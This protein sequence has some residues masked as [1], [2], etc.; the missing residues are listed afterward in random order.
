MRLL[1]TDPIAVV[2]DLPD[3]VA[4]RAEDASGSF[5]ILPHHA[6]FLTVLSTS[7]VAWRRADG[8]AGYCA[9]RGGVLTVHDGTEVAV[10]TREAQ[11]GEDLEQLE[12][13]V[14]ARF[15]AAAESERNARVAAARLHLQAIRQIVRAL[16]PDGSKRLEL[17]S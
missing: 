7:V 13:A 8:H 6:D 17:G 16:R 15:A 2:A 14:L 1:I 9:V 3:V 10:A 4:I 12:R 5:G 11:L